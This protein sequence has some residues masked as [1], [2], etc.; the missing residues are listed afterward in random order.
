MTDPITLPPEV[1]DTRRLDALRD[2][3]ILDT[4][5][6][7][8]F[9]DIVELARMT[10]AAPVALVSLVTDDRQWF[11]ARAGFAPCETSLDKS[12]C[13]HVLGSPDLLIIP[14]L[15]QDPRTREN[16]LV[17]GEP[18]LRFYAGAPLEE[19]GG[20]RLGSLCVID[21]VPR[22][23]GLDPRQ[24]TALRALAGQVMSQ[25]ELRRGAA[26]R[27]R[28]L[29]GQSALIAQQNALISAQAAVTRADGNRDAILDAL[30]GGVMDA[31]PQAEGGVIE[32]RDG[33]TLAYRAA[34]GTLAAHA[35]LR[36]PIAGSL[37]GHCLTTGKPVICPDVLL[38]PRVKRDLLV[39]LGLRSAVCVPILRG[40]ST[41]GVLKLQ[42]SRP[43]AFSG[44][45]LRIATLF[46]GAIP[47]GLAEA[48]E[49]EARR[50]IRASEA[51]LRTVME[52]LPVGVLIA[53]APTGRIVG[54][55]A[56][57]A[58]ILGHAVPLEA[59]G[60]APA[61]WVGLH[62]D[63]RP[64]EPGE[65]PLVRVAQ[66]GEAAAELEVDYRR[67]DGTRAWIGF[68]GAPMHDDDRV[69]GAVVVVTDIDGRKRA[70][71]QLA[72]AKHAAEEANRAKSEFL[73]NMSHELRTPLSA[74]I[75]YSEMLQEEME[76]LGHE[77]LLPDMRKIESNARHLLGLINDVLDLSKI[78]AER[79]E[80][81][82]EE[83]SVESLVRDV[84]STVDALVAKKGNVLT[85]DLGG[86]LGE[87]HTDAT[88]LRQCLINL[89]GN[90][91]KFTEAGR[92]TLSVARG[93][94]EGAEW[95]TFRVADT[96][97]GMSPEQQERLFE[98]FT[99][100]DAS[101]TRKFG[102]T[103]LG[104][105][106]TRAFAAML[107]GEIAVASEEG[108]GTT[109]TVSVPAR[110]VGTAAGAE[111][112]A[113]PDADGEAPGADDAEQGVV[114]VVDDDPATRELVARF[115]ERDGFR[116]AV[117]ADGR[118][119]MDKARALMPRVIL[120]DVTMPRM[121][122][123][124]VLRALR[125]DAAFATTPVVILTVLNERNLAFSL[126]ATDY[127]QKPMDWDELHRL[128]DRFRPQCRTAPPPALAE[129]GIGQA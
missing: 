64:V 96:G 44:R 19:R 65:W 110:I 4:P 55:N 100:A 26:D 85:L 30:V 34:G 2:H 8:G 61:A 127:L 53:E 22:P 107:G 102:G 35:G 95:L 51:T 18:H 73:A 50:G 121:D 63:G 87:A 12:V 5:P 47:A 29:A 118:E 9:D 39:Q 88:K 129:D 37:A 123:W 86:D 126:G 89:L 108:R 14:D 11:K 111:P 43:D 23:E 32:L 80:T 76:D 28:I 92:I 91:A 15:T 20:Q 103:G 119:G 72:A 98:R 7:K 75:G 90:A 46:A 122:G 27:E 36:V 79:M 68:S 38:D 3:D 58:A 113:P 93:D 77:N 62:A 69:V 124:S 115:L 10:C 70:E 101:T 83:F 1:A 117:A 56:R 45:D 109:F 106:I 54:H 48:G 40:R 24:A 94:R 120:L 116:V 114:L 112:H 42:S 67:G 81:Y 33:A 41:I 31:I 52:T 128:M 49:A 57:V 59:P 60:S 25:L 71:I 66:G 97:I 82:V 125:G 105:S 13:A 104:L 6:E 84:A 99:Q 74:V 16:P 21:L 17:T 78:E